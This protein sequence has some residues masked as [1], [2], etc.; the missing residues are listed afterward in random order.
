MLSCCCPASVF[1]SHPVSG[2]ALATYFFI[3]WPVSCDNTCSLRH[4]SP[5]V[6]S[7][8]EASNYA[9]LVTGLLHCH[10]PQ[11]LDGSAW[12]QCLINIVRLANRKQLHA[13]ILLASMQ[14]HPAELG[15]L[16]C[17]HLRAPSLHIA[18]VAFTSLAARMYIT[19]CIIITC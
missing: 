1:P 6:I 15:L 13:V 18:I 10:W 12:L 16:V 3:C 14:W 11:K 5:I 9:P 4:H 8:W 7:Q 17:L 2:A 19:C